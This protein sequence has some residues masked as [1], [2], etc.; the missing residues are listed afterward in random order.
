MTD[1]APLYGN[2]K[3]T[4]ADWLTVA[5]DLLVSE[6]VGEVK[7]L[8]ISE[9]L[10]VSRSSFYWYFKSRKDLLDALLEHWQQTNTAQLVRHAK[11]PAATVTEA[12]CNIFRCWV[13]A[14]LFNH[15]LD[16]AI[17]EW[18]RR[19]GAVRRIIDQ[20]DA[21]RVTSFTAMFTRFDFPD[22]EAEVRARVMYFMQVGYYA[23]ELSEP[24]EER[25][26]RTRNYVLSFT[27]RDPAQAEIDALLAYAIKANGG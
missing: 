2:T 19:D 16:F 13:D 1:P 14:D 27:G 17:R 23:L 7:V 20:T 12:V 3:V 15:K 22:D 10:G 21:M 24:L 4:R 9:R 18:A 5:L 25:I 26:K 8:S 11:M 6:G